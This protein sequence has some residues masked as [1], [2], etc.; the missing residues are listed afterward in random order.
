MTT[1]RA[2]L[3]RVAKLEQSRVRSFTPIEKWFGS[4]E[5]FE[6]E[7]RVQIVNGKLAADDT[8]AVLSALRRWHSDVAWG[9]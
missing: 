8:E 1:T 6:E 4:H 3:S 7:T 5:A 2:L 9:N